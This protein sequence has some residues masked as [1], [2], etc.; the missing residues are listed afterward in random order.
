M[1]NFLVNCMSG[2]VEVEQVTKSQVISYLKS[3]QTTEIPTEE[4]LSKFIE[5]KEIEKF[6]EFLD[7]ELINLGYGKKMFDIE[8]TFKFIKQILAK[9]NK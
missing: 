8:S 2:V 7:E 4:E 6:D 5:D 1:N 9:S 3:L